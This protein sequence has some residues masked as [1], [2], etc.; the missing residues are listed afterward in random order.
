MSKA[1][2]GQIVAS[3]APD[4][5]ALPGLQP[6]KAAEVESVSVETEPAGS[7]TSRPTTCDARP[8]AT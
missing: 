6:R 7:R 8:S 3:D 5:L 4:D 1:L 2:T